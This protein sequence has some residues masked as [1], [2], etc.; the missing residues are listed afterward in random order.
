MQ[1]VDGYCRIST[2]AQEDNTSLDEQ[3]RCIREYCAENGLLIGQ[4]HRE[5]WSGYEY[6]ERE[7]LTLMRERYHTGK[8]QGIVIR[9]FDRL[10]RKEV[11]FGILL[12]EIEHLGIELHCVKENLDDSLLGRMTRLFLGFLA[13][14]E[15]EKIR[16]RTTTGRINRAKEGKIVAGRKLPYGWKWQYDDNGDKESV[17]HHEVQVVWVRWMADQYDTGMSTNEI[18]RQL[19]ENGVLSPD[20]EPG[21][22]WHP[23]MVRRI[24]SNERLIG[25]GKNFAYQMHK[26]RQPF[27]PIDLPDN[28]Y[29]PII[30]EEKFYRI[31]D[32][33]S[34]TSIEAPRNNERP[35]E[36]L[37]RA[38]DEKLLLLAEHTELIAHAIQLATNED[39]LT[40][41]AKSIDASLDT[42]QK[43]AKNYMTDLEDPDLCG[44][45]RASIRQS[46]NAANK[47]I[48]QLKAEMHQVQLGMVDHER[49]QAAYQEILT[50]CHKVKTAGGELDYQ[51]KRDFL[52]LLGV[53]VTV[54]NKGNGVPD[55]RIEVELPEI[56]AVLTSAISV[57][58][59]CPETM[60]HDQ[61]IAPG[62][63]QSTGDVDHCVYQRTRY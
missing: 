2:D 11:H 52:H 33:L 13:E 41:E 8:I 63:H 51:H 39:N 59:H 18:A 37:L 3:E 16:E 29:P 55:C 38:G 25:K 23:F 58:E 1:V 21:K 56:Q 4:I 44:E 42:W 32:R 47:R 6:R 31:Q 24:L 15:W 35:E 10:S 7:K 19:T 9:T 50:W 20:G 5:V 48:E 53:V 61:P 49:E 57:G 14:W 30:D 40:N 26:A 45:S 12:E 17:I 34:R 43:R 28:T 22:P 36:F 60:C 46:L 54:K 27:D 62:I